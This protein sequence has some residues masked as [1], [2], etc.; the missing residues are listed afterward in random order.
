MSQGFE[1]IKKTLRRITL[2]LAGP[3][4]DADVANVLDL[5]D[6]GESGVAFET[7][8]TQL[9]EYEVQVP[10]D[11]QAE[12]APIGQQMGLAPHLWLNLD[13]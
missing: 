8:C 13:R 3:L 1:E 4:P 6:A 10:A 9:Y 7:L 11:T 5:L 12:L 2:Q